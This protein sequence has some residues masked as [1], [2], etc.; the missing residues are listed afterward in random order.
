MCKWKRDVKERECVFVFVFVSEGSEV[1]C[2]YWR[3]W[4]SNVLGVSGSVFPRMNVPPPLD[5]FNFF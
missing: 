2:L 1:F 4:D 3:V 5:N